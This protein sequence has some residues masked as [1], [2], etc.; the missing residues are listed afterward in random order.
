MTVGKASKEGSASTPERGGRVVQVDSEIE[1]KLPGIRHATLVFQK[2]RKIYMYRY[3]TASAQSEANRASSTCSVHPDV[4]K[5]K[6][7][8]KIIWS[9]TIS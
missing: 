6:S 4:M 3:D 5:C 7:I 9:Q 8:E 2:K 1:F